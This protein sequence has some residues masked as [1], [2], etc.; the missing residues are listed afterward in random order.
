MKFVMLCCCLVVFAVSETAV[1]TKNN[2]VYYFCTS[3]AMSQKE[4]KEK[5]Y[6][7]YTSIH[8]IPCD[9]QKIK[10]LTKAWADKIN[11]D[12]K[13]KTGCTSDLNVYNT[14]AEA[15]KQ[16]NGFIQMYNDPNKCFLAKEDF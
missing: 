12:C 1:A 14:A 4:V 13:N 2:T 10:A 5:Q 7:F 6:V 8:T 16:L 3:R 11:S 9:A 15:E